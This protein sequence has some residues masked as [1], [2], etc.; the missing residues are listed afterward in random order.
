[1]T[2]CD[3]YLYA[4]EVLSHCSSIDHTRPCPTRTHTPTTSRCITCV[5]TSQ[6]PRLMLIPVRQQ[7]FAASQ[8]YRWR[9][10][11]VQRVPVRR[12]RPVLLCQVNRED[13]MGRSRWMRQTGIFDDHDGCEWVNVSS[14]TG[15]PMLSLTK[16]TEP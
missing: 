14:G 1:M 4:G 10:D 15:S 13:A 11:R 12:R 2:G 7:R 6:Q 5:S 16:S 8:Q 3:A 9:N